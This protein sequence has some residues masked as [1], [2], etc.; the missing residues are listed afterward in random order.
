KATFTGGIKAV[1]NVL[2]THR[3]TIDRLKLYDGSGLSRDNR[4]A[5]VT[6]VELLQQAGADDDTAALLTTLPT[7]AFNGTLR[8]RFDDADAARGL[9]HAKSGTL[10]GV[11]TLAG[12]VLDANGSVIYFAVMADD[13]DAGY[14]EA[15]K[16]EDAVVSALARC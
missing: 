8:G 1:R 5:P 9:A 10:T 7:A 2:K 3:I 4:I 12:T 15:K 14:A 6:L 13:L 11:T 16:A